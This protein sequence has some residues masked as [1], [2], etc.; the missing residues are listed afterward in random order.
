MRDKVT[1]MNPYIVPRH[2]GNFRIQN[3]MIRYLF[4]REVMRI[5]PKFCDP[6]LQKNTM[7]MFRAH[8][9]QSLKWLFRFSKIY[10]PERYPVNFY[11]SLATYKGAIPGRWNVSADEKKFYDEFKDKATE[12]MSGYDYVVDIDA[13]DEKEIKE[14][15]RA[16]LK[17]H[18]MFNDVGL[19]HDMRFTGGGFHIIVPYQAF[20]KVPHSFNPYDSLSIYA[21]HTEISLALYN[22]VSE[23]VDHS[24]HDSRRVVKIPFS[25]SMCENKNY[26]VHPISGYELMDFNPVIYD[27]EFYGVTHARFIREYK[28]GVADS[29]PEAINKL[30]SKLKIKWGDADGNKKKNTA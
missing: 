3:L 11:Y 23:F 12:Y 30:L 2:Y 18:E 29:N 24:I 20:E 25:V 14:A 10:T 27:A 16:T 19:R 26:V 1:R 6:E 13:P 17:I 4:R 7:R 28:P 5:V 15:A 8:N 9:T 22:T 21:L